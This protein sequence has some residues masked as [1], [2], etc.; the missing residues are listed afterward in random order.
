MRQKDSAFYIVLW[1]RLLDPKLTT[2]MAVI[3]S[4][5]WSIK[6]HIYYVRGITH[7]KIESVTSNAS[8]NVNQLLTTRRTEKVMSVTPAPISS[9]DR[10]QPLRVMSIRI[11]NKDEN[12]LII[13]L[14]YPSHRVKETIIK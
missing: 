6:E 8:G 14:L 11:T 4:S 1:Y 10:L 3:R 13:N 2:D 9:R 12:C 7:H 5:Q